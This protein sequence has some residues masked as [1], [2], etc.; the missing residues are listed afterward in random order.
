MCAES[1]FLG[2]KIGSGREHL[3]HLLEDAVHVADPVDELS[4]RRNATGS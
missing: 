1:H 3:P 4:D 2:M